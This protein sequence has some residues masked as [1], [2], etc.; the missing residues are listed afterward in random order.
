M[1][2]S[3]WT[4]QNQKNTNNTTYD[5]NIKKAKDESSVQTLRHDVPCHGL[6][7]ERYRKGK[8]GSSDG[9]ICGWVDGWVLIR[10]SGKQ[11][12]PLDLLVWW[13]RKCV[14]LF[15]VPVN[16]QNTHVST[17]TH[18]NT[19]LNWTDHMQ[20]FR[21]SSTLIPTDIHSYPNRHT[22]IPHR[23]TLIPHRYTHTHTHHTCCYQT[24][25]IAKYCII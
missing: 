23:Y 22:L 18:I 25:I 1:I 11:V 6:V 5:T 8:V 10:A 13:N 7:K 3:S 20:T 24:V 15:T 17:H 2:D 14:F 12:C 16:K 4:V 21:T 19:H 9:W